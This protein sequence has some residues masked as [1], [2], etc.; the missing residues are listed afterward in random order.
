MNSTPVISKSS[1][2]RGKQCHKSL[3]LHLHDPGLKDAISDSQQHIFNIGHD[4]GKLAQQLFPGGID[5]SRAQPHEVKEAIAYTQQLIS[6][7]QEVIY[8]AAFSNGETLCYMDLL[9]KKNGEWQAFEVKASTGVKDYHLLDISFQYFVICQSGLPLK[10]ISLVYLNNQYVRRGEIDVDQLFTIV[11]LTD[12]AKGM[13]VS[14]QENLLEMQNMLVLGQHPEIASGNQ[15]TQPFACDFYG[16]CH[17]DEQSD[18]FTELTGVRGYKIERL[19]SLE[20]KSFEE[21]PANMAFTTR[22][23]TVLKGLFNNENRREPAS[24]KSFIERLIYPLH[25]LDFETIMLAVPLYVESRPYQQ[26]TFQFS[27]HKQERP[28]SSVLHYEFLANPPEDPRPAFIKS[29]L[30]SIEDEGSIIVYNKAFEQTRIRELARDF[31]EFAERLSGVNKRMVDLMEPFR[32]Q[33]FYMPDMRGSHSIKKVLPAL[34]PDLSY[35]DLEIQAG[36]TA[37]LIYLSLYADTDQASI[38]RKRDN[39]LKY[40]E[41]DTWGMVRV[42]EKIR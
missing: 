9:V 34:V 37:S 19:R 10:E 6:A 40:C 18:I 31:P 11:N 3:Y 13:Q 14:V 8:E 16:Y 2:I 24:L 7:G 42:L 15:C 1:F 25:F 30:E 33:Q 23:W 5:A 32:N 38:I 36:D 29:L 28:E 26:L 12:H 4:T 17:K 27:L 41:M 22:E 39:L 35:S 20:V 21:I